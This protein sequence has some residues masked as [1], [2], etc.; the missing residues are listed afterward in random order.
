[1]REGMWEASYIQELC[2]SLRIDLEQFNNSSFN[3]NIFSNNENGDDLWLHDDD[4][5]D[6]D[7]RWLW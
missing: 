1:M 6:D 3:K 5:D 2:I 7:Q 4:D